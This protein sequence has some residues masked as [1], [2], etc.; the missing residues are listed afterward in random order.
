MMKIMQEINDF[1]NERD[2]GQFHTPKNLAGS[3]VIETAE[4]MECFQW[5]SPSAG[6][7]ALN[8]DR[9]ISIK[10]ELADVMIYTIRLCSILSLDPIEIM[11]EKLEENRKKYPIKLSRGSPKKYDDL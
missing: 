5:D 4:L 6:E 11:G 2:W 10:E 8:N 9:M 3:I 7:L 1:V